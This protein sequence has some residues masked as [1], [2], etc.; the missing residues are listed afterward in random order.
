MSKNLEVKI[1]E[2]KELWPHFH[3]PP[4]GR[5]V[6]RVLDNNEANFRGAQGQMSHNVAVEK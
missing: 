3:I 5:D 2:T 1:R 6:L 4:V